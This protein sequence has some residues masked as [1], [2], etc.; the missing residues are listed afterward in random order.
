MALD[1]VLE[2]FGRVLQLAENCVLEV[3]SE[4]VLRVLERLVVPLRRPVQPLEAGLI[5][6]GFRAQDE[7]LYGN[8]NLNRQQIV[9]RKV[10]TDE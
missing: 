10:C 8:E 6:V 4:H 1:D 2:S 3:V 9:S 7:R 5:I